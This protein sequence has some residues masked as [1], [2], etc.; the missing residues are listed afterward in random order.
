MWSLALTAVSCVAAGTAPRLTGGT[1]GEVDFLWQ[2]TMGGAAEVYYAHADDSAGAS[3]WPRSCRQ[4][5]VVLVL[6]TVSPWSQPV[7]R[8]HPSTGFTG[9]L[10]WY[11][12][13]GW[14][15]LAVCHWHALCH[16]VC[17]AAS[18]AE[19]PDTAEVKARVFSAHAFELWKEFARTQVGAPRRTA[20]GS[21][22]L[23]GPSRCGSGVIDKRRAGPVKALALS[24]VT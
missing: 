20:S 19:A 1:P 17:A 23:R 2:S 3:E 15:C 21:L 12:L 24:T 5:S 9:G 7:C 14:H 4:S 6:V 13:A 11:S 22:R 18:D 16:A 10:W 8:L